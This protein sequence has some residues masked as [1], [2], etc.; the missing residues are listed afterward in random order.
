MI[1]AETLHLILRQHDPIRRRSSKPP[2]Q[3]RQPTPTHK[4]QHRIQNANAPRRLRIRNRRRPRGQL[5]R[6]IHIRPHQAFV[7]LERL[8]VVGAVLCDL[9]GEDVR[10]D[11]GDGGAHSADGRRAVRRV[12]DDGHAALGPA[13]EFDLGVGLH[14]EVVRIIHGGE[15]AGG[16]PAGVG[17]E[18][19]HERLLLGLGEPGVVLERLRGAAHDGEEDHCFAGV[20]GPGEDAAPPGGVVPPGPGAVGFARGDAEVGYV[21]VQGADAGF[22][23]VGEDEGAGGRAETV[24]CDEEVEVSLG[25]GVGEGDLDSVL[26]VVDGFDIIAENVL[27]A[28]FCTIIQNLCER[29]SQYL[30]I[31]R[32]TLPLPTTIDSEL[33]S[34]AI[35]GINEGEALFVGRVLLNR[36]FQSHAPYYF[37]TSAAEIYVLAYCPQCGG[38]LDD[39]YVCTGTGKPESESWTGNASA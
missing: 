5:L 7:P 35:V 24:A 16:L 19:V 32:K 12:A 3:S 37:K 9:A 1:S 33:R 8:R 4:P 10:A 11:D 14:V 26:G 25:R 28:V 21:L 15:D 20:V 2:Q 31:R 23:H 30:S 13:V 36:I 17:E 22:L 18:V 34:D 27:R 38:A 39:C 29:S 6:L